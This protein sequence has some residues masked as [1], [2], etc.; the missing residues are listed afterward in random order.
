VGNPFHHHQDINRLLLAWRKPET[1]IVQEPWWTSTARHADIVL[2]CTTTL[3]RNDFTA[4]HCD[5]S[6]QAM[7][8]AVTPRGASRNEYDIFTDLADVLGFKERF[9]EGRDETK[10]LN[11]L[12]DKTRQSAA[13]KGVELPDFQAFWQEGE[14]RYPAFEHAE[15]L[16]KA[17]REDP[18]GNPLSTPSGKIE[19]YSETIASFSYDNCPP[20]PMWIE[21]QEWLGSTKVARYPFHLISNQPRDKLHSQLDFAVN[22]REIK[23]R[24]RTPLWINPEDAASK[25]LSDRDIL[26]VYNDRGA[27]L[28]GVIISGDVQKGV[29][30]LPTGSWYDPEM[31]GVIGA[32]DVHGN[33]N[34]LTRDV[35]TSKL[36]QGPSA[37]SCLVDIERYD[38]A[39]PAV[40]VHE[41]PQII[42]RLCR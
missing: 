21:P 10:W 12:Y 28:A 31:P 29:V 6:L 25:N 18:E 5:W 22:S 11:H 15:V 36:S 27:C 26:R 33:P 16:F 42:E 30:I 41:P 9:T 3:E 19:I 39:P 8:Q 4:G 1:I 14:F 7:Q 13:G 32:L 35:G 17:F 34:V 23:V 37:Q 2:P 20:H 38:G 40:K 24:E